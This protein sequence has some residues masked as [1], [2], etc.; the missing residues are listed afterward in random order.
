[1]ATQK[2]KIPLPRDVGVDLPAAMTLSG[3]VEL[4]SYTPFV[5]DERPALIDGKP[6]VNGNPLPKGFEFAIPFANTDQGRWDTNH[7]A[8]MRAPSG[9]TSGKDP[10][11]K[12]MDQRL[13]QPWAQVDPLK[14]AIDQV[15]E[16]G[17]RHRAL[18]EGVCNKRGLRGW[19]PV[20]DAKGDKVKV[21][22][23]FLGR[24]PEQV[25]EQRNEHYRKIG[26]EDLKRVE[27]DYQLDQEK[28]GRSG[29]KG[30]ST[31]Q[32]GDVLTDTGDPS[33]GASIGFEQVRGGG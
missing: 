18:S 22:R 5:S 27:E 19:E 11:A 1:M 31:L 12:A 20:L 23:L 32:R 7:G 28:A 29:S 4:G 14:A 6:T 9:I 17:F 16:P 30:V 2:P 3:E 24:M 15:A 26:G 33:R 21:G 8:N 13:D 25:A 10:L